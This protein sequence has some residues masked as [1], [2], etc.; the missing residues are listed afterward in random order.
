MNKE[1]EIKCLPD[2]SVWERHFGTQNARKAK[3]VATICGWKYEWI[4]N[5]NGL[6][7]P[8]RRSDCIIIRPKEYAVPV[9][10]PSPMWPADSPVE[11][12]KLLRRFAFFD[13]LAYLGDHIPLPVCIR[14]ARL[15][16]KYGDCELV[17]GKFVIRLN[18]R[19]DE[20]RLIDT[21]IH[22]WAHGLAWGLE[23]DFHG[24][25][26][27]VAYSRV[28]RVFLEWNKL[29]LASRRALSQM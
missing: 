3:D 4:E 20:S 16:G 22:E 19:L 13:L 12:G 2:G 10:R 6:H 24:E 21:L 26:W 17:K 28:Y 29:R 14:F 9:H 8:L 27:G 15:S 7:K 5:A 23:E 18:R 25:K 11:L 1:P